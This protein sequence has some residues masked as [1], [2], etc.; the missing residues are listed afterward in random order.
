MTQELLPGALGPNQ[1]W[2]GSG[3]QPGSGLEKPRFPGPHDRRDGPDVTLILFVVWVAIAFALSTCGGGLT[4]PAF[5]H[6]HDETNA[7]WFMS[8]KQ[9]DTVGI[10]G[11]PGVS[12]CGPA[13]QYYA[14]QYEPSKATPN[15]YRALVGGF[16]WIEIPPNK[17]IRGKP[18][19]TGRA[20]VFVSRSEAQFGPDRVE[21]FVY[22]FVPTDEV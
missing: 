15:G 4:S 10:D 3:Y 2:P 8:L 20:V 18:N 19:P 6:S 21:P 1:R 12:C 5:G 17:V 16:G 13:D 22:C 11:T 7:E 9:P 14:E